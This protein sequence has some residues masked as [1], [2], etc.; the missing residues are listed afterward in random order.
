IVWMKTT[1]TLEDIPEDESDVKMPVYSMHGHI[2]SPW[3]EET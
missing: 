1:L 2:S 3:E